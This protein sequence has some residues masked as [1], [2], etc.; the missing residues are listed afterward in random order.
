[1]G[2]PEKQELRV[3]DAE[4][5][6][7]VEQ[8]RTHLGAGRL[9]LDEFEERTAQALA[10][11]TVGDLVP[12]TAD[13]PA[14]RRPLPKGPP[15]RQVQRPPAQG[16]DLAWRIHKAVWGL[17]AAFLVLIWLLTTPTGYFWPIWPVLGIGVSVGIHGAV[18]KAVEGG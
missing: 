12:L 14:V 2:V 9:E 16:W 15:I 11:R 8:L 4:R 3:G 6:A 7:V 17:L 13:L 1:M 18:K 5:Q 10:A